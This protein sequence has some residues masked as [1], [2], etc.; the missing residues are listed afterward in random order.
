MN[1]GK[2]FE[3]DFKNSCPDNV[4]IMRLKD[5][6]FGTNPCDF[7]VFKKPYF[8]MFEL[9]T[10]K[11]KRLPK[12]MVRPHQ[13]KSLNIANTLEG[14]VGGFIVNFREVNETYFMDGRKMY[15]LFEE[16]NLKSI[17]LDTFRKEGYRIPQQLKRVRYR[18]DFN[19]LDGVVECK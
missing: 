19:F 16:E 14:V 11:L 6:S 9:K 7:I 12:D 13:L 4:L 10:T 17:S 5:G 2:L 3:Q 8:F 18:Y 15:K 1:V